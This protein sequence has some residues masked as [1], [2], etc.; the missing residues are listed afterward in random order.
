MLQ[1]KRQLNHG[2]NLKII[3]IKCENWA[4]SPNSLAQLASYNITSRGFMASP[5]FE[6]STRYEGQKAHIILRL[7]LPLG[8][9]VIHKWSCLLFPTPHL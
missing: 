7:S 1:F 5:S 4:Q 3:Q 2:K 6:A 9:H 8:A